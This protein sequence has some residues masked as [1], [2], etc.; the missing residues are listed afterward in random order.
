MVE[1]GAALG[2]VGAEADGDVN[3]SRSH[4]DFDWEDWTRS[5]WEGGFLEAACLLFVGAE[6]KSPKPQSSSSTAGGEETLETGALGELEELPLAPNPQSSSRLCVCCCTGPFL[7]FPRVSSP[8]HAS[9]CLRDASIFRIASSLRWESTNAARC[10]IV[11]FALLEPA[12]EPDTRLLKASPD[13]AAPTLFVGFDKGGA[14]GLPFAGM[15]D[16]DIDGFMEDGAYD[17]VIERE[18]EVPGAD[19]SM[20]NTSLAFRYGTLPFDEDDEPSFGGAWDGL[21]GTV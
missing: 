11:K 14:T 8:A 2:L 7:P 9:L 16:P 6:P 19:A 4:K 15:L 3:S 17:G 18:V 12:I 13:P 5:G 20:A 21:A 1:R 10:A